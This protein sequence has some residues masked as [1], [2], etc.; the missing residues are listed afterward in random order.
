MKPRYDAE[1]AAAVDWDLE[2]QDAADRIAAAIKRMARTGGLGTAAVAA[3]GSN[4]R[5][6]KAAL[7]NI[8][9]VDVSCALVTLAE[10]VARLRKERARP[11]MPAAGGYTLIVG[12]FGGTGPGVSDDGD[13]YGEYVSASGDTNIPMTTKSAIIG[14]RVED[15][16][17]CEAV[18]I[19]GEKA[20]DISA[21]RHPDGRIEDRSGHF[22][23]SEDAWVKFLK[24]NRRVRLI[25]A[26]AKAKGRKRL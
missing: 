13:E 5:H 23:D 7:P 26:D 10:A 21:V 9:P 6:V 11:I 12:G 3:I 18:T 16:G 14:W 4:A 24:Y 22:F 17:F 15:D 25:E 2:T 19:A 1:A 8:D 20:D